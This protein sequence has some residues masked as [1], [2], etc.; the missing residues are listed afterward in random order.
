MLTQTLPAYPYV[1]Y[2]DDADIT[3]FFTAYNNIS[4]TYLN[5]INDLNLPVYTGS[6]IVGAL[7]D[8]VAQGI[9]GI[10]R[11]TLPVGSTFS[12]QGVYNTIEYDTEAYN[13]DIEIN[14]NTYY[15][16]TDDYFKR[17]LTWNL[18]RGDGYQ[19]TCDWLKR[20]VK[21]FLYGVNGVDFTI[22]NTYEISV[23]YSGSTITITIPNLT[24]S[25][26]FKAAVQAGALNLPFQYT[27]NIIY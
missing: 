24:I 1:Q 18:Y 6:A 8:W 27:Y 14:P 13:Q 21:R 5:N 7:L 16:V 12:N 15:T 11:P 23:T 26:I 4:Q 2:A 3:A 25:P 17:I 19:F 20:R 10:T 22:D 9:Y